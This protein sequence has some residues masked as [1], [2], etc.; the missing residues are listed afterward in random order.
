NGAYSF[1]PFLQSNSAADNMALFTIAEKIA[2]KG[3][4]ALGPSDAVLGKYSNFVAETNNGGNT[5]Y[6]ATPSAAPTPANEGLFTSLGA[7]LPHVV[8]LKGHTYSFLPAG[9]TVKS[10]LHFA[11][12][13]PDTL[14]THMKLQGT[15][16]SA[17]NDEMVVLTYTTSDVFPEVL[18]RK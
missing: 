12:I 9:V 10:F 14:M 16:V 11:A 17:A 5:Y 15:G 8:L 13:G 1:S 18:M 3:E 2:R 4:D 7:A 6:P